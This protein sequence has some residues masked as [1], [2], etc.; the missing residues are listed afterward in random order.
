MSDDKISDKQ[1]CIKLF[2]S[3][4]HDSRSHFDIYEAFCSKYI[5][6]KIINW[7]IKGSNSYTIRQIAIS[8]GSIIFQF[9]SC[10]M[11]NDQFSNKLGE[12][13]PHGKLGEIHEKLFYGLLRRVD[14]V[15]MFVRL[16][17]IQTMHNLIESSTKNLGKDVEGISS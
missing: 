1:K 8:V 3:K 13:I 14:D 7:L 2:F 10:Q 15:N 5:R 6:S 12:A 16:R 4:I 11:M 9:I 17:A